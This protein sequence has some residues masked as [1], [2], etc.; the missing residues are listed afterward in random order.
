M[1]ESCLAI[2]KRLDR[3]PEAESHA[4]RKRHSGW[5]HRRPAM[6]TVDI[7][8]GMQNGPRGQ[9][10]PPPPG[11]GG[12]MSPIAM[13]LLGLVAYKAI[14]HLSPDQP[15]AVPADRGTTTA[16]SPSG[17]SLGGMLGPLGGLLSG[18]AA[19]SVLS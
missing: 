17:G 11:G 18:G 9:P 6:G 12:G 3:A 19:G 15:N 13:A 8:N 14:K 1:A 10:T 7:F 2:S 5:V 4:D 16:E